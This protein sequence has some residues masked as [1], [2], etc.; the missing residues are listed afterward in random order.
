M[1][2]LTPQMQEALKGLHDIRLPA[3]VGWWPLAPGWWALGGLVLLLAAAVWLRR[4]RR[5]QKAAAL[6]EWKALAAR[7]PADPALARDLAAL[8]RRVALAREGGVAALEGA[9]WAERLTGGKGFSGE[10]AAWLATAPYAPAT[11]PE[12]ARRALAE[13]RPWIA[14]HA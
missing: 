9:G 14:R 3:P 4:R 5:G 10:V 11:D 1:A 13:A 2:D 7:G 8:V 6:R 12:A